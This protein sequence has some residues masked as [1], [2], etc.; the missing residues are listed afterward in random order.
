MSYVTHHNATRI[1]YGETKVFVT[2]KKPYTFG[3]KEQ[4]RVF[5]RNIFVLRGTVC[6][7]WFSVSQQLQS[8]K[9]TNY[10]SC[11]L[12]LYCCTLYSVL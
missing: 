7:L 12:D 1:P 8:T 10:D 3:R 4:K 6:C 2:T 9:N 11:H 5:A